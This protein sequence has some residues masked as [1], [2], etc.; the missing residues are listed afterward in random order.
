M[1]VVVRCGCTIQTCEIATEVLG[2]FYGKT[3]AERV[4]RESSQDKLHDVKIFEASIA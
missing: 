1:F 4:A 3:S 2:I